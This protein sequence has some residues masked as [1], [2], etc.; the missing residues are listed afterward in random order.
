MPD[1]ADGPSQDEAPD[2]PPEASDEAQTPSPEQGADT[3]QSADDQAVDQPEAEAEA[4]EPETPGQQAQGPAD[5]SQAEP[6]AA[7]EEAQPAAEAEEDAAQALLKAMLQAA[8]QAWTEELKRPV[9]PGEPSVLRG[10][11]EAVLGGGEGRYVVSSAAWRGAGTG[12]AY[13]AL[14]AELAAGVAACAQAAS[15][16]GEPDLEAAELDD[17]ALEAYQAAAADLWT[18]AAEAARTE[19]RT[20]LAVDA[21]ESRVVDLSETPAAE[22][23]E[24][25][26]Y[27]AARADLTVEGLPEA[28]VL[29]VVPAAAVAQAPAEAPPGPEGHNVAQIMKMRLPV[30][31]TVAER[32]MRLSRIM[33]LVPGA[34]IEFRKSAEEPLDLQAAGITIGRGEA[35]IVRERFGLQVRE[36]FTRKAIRAHRDES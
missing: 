35:V 5:E 7:G 2:R 17:Q 14:G 21:G 27:V 19:G 1:Q 16:G 6:E 36:I 22:A 20:G 29:L 18:K 34:I 11:P 33:D 25:G 9:R 24:A 13:W 10:G 4:Q 32:S 12:T 15:A 28:Q 26:E 23:L 31:V 8:A 3:G 30:Y